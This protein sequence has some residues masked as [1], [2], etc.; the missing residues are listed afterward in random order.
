M[1][2]KSKFFDTG[3]LKE[4]KIF[5]PNEVLKIATQYESFINEKNLS[6]AEAV[7]HKSKTHLYFEWANQIIKNEKIINIVKEILEKIYIVG[8]LLFFI[9]PLDQT[10]SFQCIRIKITEESNMIKL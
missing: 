5:E 10:N 4:I 6:N 8:I 3:Y 1:S 2:L 7:E 9:N